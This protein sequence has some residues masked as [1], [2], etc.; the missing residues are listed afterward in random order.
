MTHFVT[1]AS[2]SSSKRR[3]RKLKGKDISFLKKFS[4]VLKVPLKE[5]QN[6]LKYTGKGCYYTNP[7]HYLSTL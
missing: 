2:K 7:T 4:K 1:F 6:F 3:E 5:D